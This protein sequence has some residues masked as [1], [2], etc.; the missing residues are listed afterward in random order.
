MTDKENSTQS[1]KAWWQPAMALFLRMSTWIVIPVIIAAFIG[2]WIDSKY[3]S[4]PWALLLCV[5]LSFFVSMVGIVRIA[6]R[7]YEK[8]E[9]SEEA[10]KKI[11]NN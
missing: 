10:K 1:E 11:K 3:D 5:G 7:E 8:V 2:K 9:I 4:D 6:N